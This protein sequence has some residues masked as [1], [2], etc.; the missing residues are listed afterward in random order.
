[1]KLFKMLKKIFANQRTVFWLLLGSL[2]LPNLFMLFTESTSVFTRICSILFPFSLYWF[3]F[4]LSKRPGKTFLWLFYIAFID[5]FQ[6]VLLYLYGES[7]IAVDMFLNVVTTNVKEAGE[8][9][10]NIFIPVVF[11]IVVYLGGVVLSIYSIVNKQV[12]S[13]RFL[14]VQRRFSLLMIVL[15]VALIGINYMVDEKRFA[16]ED[17]IFP[18]NSTYNLILSFNRSAQTHAYARN[19]AHFSYHASSL[20]SDTVPEV[21]VLVIGETARADHFGLYGYSR[22]TTPH[23]S[24]MHGEIVYFRDA[25]SMNNTT[26]KSVPLLLTSVGGQSDFDSVYYHKGIISA[27]NEAGFNTAFFSNQRRNHSLIDFMGSEAKQVEFLKDGLPLTVNVSDDEL[28]SRL[29]TTLGHMKGGKLFIVLHC[30]GSHFLYQDRYIGKKSIFTPDI[31]C[32][33]VKKNRTMLVNAYDNT[34]YYTDYL[35]YRVITSLK[36]AHV[37]SA[38]FYVSDHGEDIFDDHR[39]RF[40]H[41]SPL[42]TYYQLHVPMI[43]WASG[44]WRT[45]HAD[46]WKTL[47]D[48]CC[49]PVS[50]NRVLF[51]TMLDMCGVTT[52]YYNS[53]NAVSS[54]N[55]RPATRMYVD[56]HNDYLPVRECG[57]KKCDIEQFHKHHL[58]I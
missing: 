7:P 10:S 50:T 21:Y 2:I 57:L 39:G 30:Y 40:L 15:S 20:R 53:H 16:I 1:M 27:F 56:D 14:A 38:M 44:E 9:L 51:H 46:K 58:A 24:A 5:A 26:H 28:L 17:D 8:L 32:N 47:Q 42:P 43:I 11:V 23:L 33:A 22:N 36:N 6:I 35:L 18:I 54:P 3:A 34:I 55:Y 31:P 12:L 48:N 25:I 49:K 4:T 37:A 52:G 13:N 29:H 19:S 45:V 41:A